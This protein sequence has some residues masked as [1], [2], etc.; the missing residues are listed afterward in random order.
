MCAT[1]KYYYKD[2]VY[3]RAYTEVRLL[4][5]LRAYHSGAIITNLSRFT[6]SINRMNM[7]LQ[8]IICHSQMDVQSIVPTSC[9]H[10]L[11]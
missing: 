8:S 3:A 10:T 11:M 5:P 2:A 1:I 6:V 7:I 4:C 9:R